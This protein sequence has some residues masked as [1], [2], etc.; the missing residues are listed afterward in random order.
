MPRNDSKPNL[1]VTLEFDKIA[2]KASEKQELVFSLKNE[3]E[4]TI[5]ILKWHT[6]LEGFKSNMFHVES[7]GKRAVY[8][9][10]V[11]KRG[12]PTQDDY[13]TINPGEIVEH[14]V[15]FTEA[16]DI[17]DAGHY[18]VRYKTGLLQAGTEEPKAL[19]KKYMVPRRVEAI[20][21]KSNVAIFNLQDARQPKQLNGIH[22]EWMKMMKSSG[23]SPKLP[24]FK[25][26]SQ[27]QQSTIKTALTQAVTIAAEAKSALSNAPIWARHSAQ[28]YRE[29]FGKY[30][31]SRYDNAMTHY[32]KIWDALANKDITFN[33]DCSE[34]AYAYVY[35]T[36][37]YEIYLCK[38]FW[39]APLTGTDSQGGTILHE[40]SHFNV[41]ASTD[42]HI[43]GQ[44][45]CRDLAKNTPDDAIDNADSHEYFAENTPA[46]TMDP[47]PGSIIRI[48]DQWRKMPAGFKGSFDSALN[49]GG[50]FTGKCYFFKGDKYIRYDWV[51]DRAD[52]GYPKK[53][54]DNW[55]NLPAGFTSNFD[56]AVNGQGPFAGK[57]YF[58]KGDS[59]IRY[60]W[61]SDR[62]DPGYPKKI[63]NNWHNLP[64]GFKD[65]FDAIINGGGPFKGKCYFFKGDKYIRYD[66]VK[67]SVDAGYP[68]KISDNWH[69]LPNG[70]TGNFD[71]ALE[72]DKNFSGKGYFFK[73]DFYI[74]YNWEGDYAEE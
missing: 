49:G 8:L 61:S 36:K 9:G 31:K 6:P 52:T 59:Y 27:A 40:T 35:P 20:A 71:A 63:A 64:S 19:M 11:Y 5:R 32:E 57:C 74:R 53:I 7:A 45:G 38:A 72:G 50:P 42:D 13:I 16:Y 33:C 66:W 73:G 18:S 22:V 4:K 47:V 12:V 67:D 21:V 44:V 15:D 10:R 26:C 34:S 30:E 60:D 24:S 58:F 54:A 37:P 70:F 68:K 1:L 56:A 17:A 29:W 48:T 2:Y 43:Y 39:T 62:V 14:K 41:V 3:S 46:L 25:G 51:K 28:R 65:N 69:C 55:H 23:I